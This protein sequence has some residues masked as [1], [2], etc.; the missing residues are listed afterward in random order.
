MEK[1]SS[2]FPPSQ[3]RNV[4]AFPCT[5]AREVRTDKVGHSLMIWRAHFGYTR[6]I[7][8]WDGVLQLR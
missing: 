6:D 4:Q 8:L 3:M 7:D 2:E 1:L 5:S